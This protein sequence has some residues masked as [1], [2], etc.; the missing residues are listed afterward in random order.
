MHKYWGKKPSNDLKQLIEKYSNEGDTLLDPFAGYGVFC[1]EA[2]ILNRNIISNDLNPVANYINIQLLEKDINLP[3]LERQWGQIKTD[4]LPFN[5]KWFKFTHNNKSIL[6]T[7]ILRDKNDI[8]VMGKFREIGSRKSSEFNF[9]NTEAQEYLRFEEKQI[10]TDWYPTIDLIKNS[11][12]SAKEG[13]NVSDLFTK[14]TL[15]CHARLLT[16]I[17][18]H[19]TGKEKDFLKVAFTAN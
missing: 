12:I 5:D 7:A 8:P 1:S 9:S 14:R 10:I 15:A 19:S 3:L 13:M 2:F 11:R 18:K 4:F 6:L 17:E 16:L